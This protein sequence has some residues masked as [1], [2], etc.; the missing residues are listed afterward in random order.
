MADIVVSGERELQIKLDKLQNFDATKALTKIGLKM[1]TEAK[2]KCPVDTGTLRRSITFEVEN[3]ELTVGTNV[4]YAP[5][6]E[7]GTGIYAVNG[8][9]RDTPWRY[10][11]ADGEWH[12]TQGQPAQPFLFNTF[13]ENKDK[14]VEYIVDEIRK[15]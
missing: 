10:E 6:L 14:A 12:T 5:Y 4:E 11:S 2:Q 8:D 9:G 13:N 15:I 7:F 3:N 1:E